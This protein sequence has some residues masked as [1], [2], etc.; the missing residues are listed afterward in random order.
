MSDLE[1]KNQQQ[2]RPGYF[3]WLTEWLPGQRGLFVA[4]LVFLIS[5]PMIA[6]V[7]YIVLP[8]INTN[9]L[10]SEIALH[11]SEADSNLRN[12]AGNWDKASLYHIAAKEI[13][14]IVQ[15]NRLSLAAKDSI[16]LVLNLKDSTISIEIKG[17]TVHTAR[18]KEVFVSHRILKAEHD[19]LIKWIDQPFAF[20]Q[21]LSTIAKTPIL[22][23]DAPKDTSEAARLPRKPLEP[24]KDFVQY[25]LL[26]DR[27]LLLEIKQNEEPLP[28]DAPQIAR[29]QRSYDSTFGTGFFKKLTDPLPSNRLVK[30]KMTLPQADARTIFRAMPHSSYARLILIPPYENN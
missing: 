17:L 30:I 4:F 15:R 12:R 20:Q 13:Q 9:L 25:S 29:Y 19:A 10:P 7:L 16:Y 22:V 6:L 26:F 24:E 5:L 28:E 8:A 11:E 2:D 21:E 3:S 27:Q 14:Q 1:N 18:A 23:V